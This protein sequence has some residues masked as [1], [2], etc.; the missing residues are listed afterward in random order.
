[1]APKRGSSRRSQRSIPYEE[2]LMVNWT[3]ARL[4]E[5]C[6]ERGIVV[7]D[8]S[9]RSQ[10]IRR[11]RQ[12]DED[13]ANGVSRG[14]TRRPAD[15]REEHAH[16]PDPVVDSGDHNMTNANE[17]ETVLNSVM[18]SVSAL[19]RRLDELERRLP[20]LPSS[21]TASVSSAV[22]SNSAHLQQQ[23]FDSSASVLTAMTSNVPTA[24]PEAPTA[25]SAHML[26]SSHDNFTL[27]TAYAEFLPRMV[28]A[29]AGSPAQLA[30]PVPR[31][32][33]IKT[34]YGYIA[35]SLPE[36]VA[37]APALRQAIIQGKDVNL[38]ALLI[39][40][41]RGSG[42]NSERS[43]RENRAPHR[44][45]T[46]AQF[47]EAFSKFKSIMCSTFPQRRPELDAYER[48][49]VTMAS[50]HPGSGFYE[51]HC[52]FSQKAAAFLR[53][54]N[55][56]IDWSIRDEMLYNNIFSGRP[57][58]T[59][60]NCG[61]TAHATGFCIFESAP[62]TDNQPRQQAERAQSRPRN[63]DMHGRPRVF[64]NNK[65]VCNNYNTAS[66]CRSSN[67]YRAHVCISCKGDHSKQSCPLD[68]AGPPPKSK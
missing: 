47:I 21:P 7:P 40:Y 38:A 35:Q 55:I 1:M 2:D 5:E 30:G 20:T 46:I 63:N 61:S 3:L 31:S 14:S 23:N 62:V 26:R 59:C 29:A 45:L 54:E 41:F 13:N 33:A 10:L 65:E 49:I 52:Q 8:S 58:L 68:R 19:N 28:P 12:H 48:L 6:R 22:N 44:P 43:D 34:Q 57:V 64:V 53:H 18:D 42:D 15:L 16:E 37:V 32:S 51:Y 50:R 36:V 4:R 60:T 27:D 66:G 56:A 17:L 24:L 67:C 25:V 39:P 11:I 9:R